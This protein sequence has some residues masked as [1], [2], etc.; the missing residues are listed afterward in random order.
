MLANCWLMPSYVQLVLLLLHQ[1]VQ[2]FM[3]KGP[4]AFMAEMVS[5]QHS[6][7][8]KHQQEPLVPDNQQHIS[9]THSAARQLS[10]SAQRRETFCDAL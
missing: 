8:S 2:E 10:T 3:K 9:S 6:R 4:Q 5:A 7:Q 1:Q